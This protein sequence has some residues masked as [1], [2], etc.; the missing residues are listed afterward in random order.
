MSGDNDLQNNAPIGLIAGNGRFPFL[1]AHGIKNAGRQVVCVAL[2]EEADKSI[3]KYCDKVFFISIGKFQKILDAF[4]ES[5]VKEVIMAGQVKHVT[6][7]AAIKMDLRAVKVMASLINKKTDTMLK[8][9][10]GE[11][12]K[13]GMSLIPSHCFLKE[14]MAKKG[15][16][17]GIELSEAEAA[18]A[19]F[20]FKMAKAIAGLDIGQTVAVKDLSVLA[21]ESVEGTDECIKRAACLGGKHIIV[22]KVAKPNQDFRFDVPV[23]GPRT[24]DT[25]KKN[26]VR[27]MIIEAN[28]TLILDEEEVMKKA[29]SY[30]LTIMAV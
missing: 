3:E 5:G 29:N 11:F 8:T 15:L 12:E 28:S 2:K 27:A 21:V 17:A 25:L 13:E 20:G 18:D 4:R 10:A 30:G 22:C 1:A 24:M 14:F 23:I 7:Y 9:F 6:I 19:D 26:K 16:I